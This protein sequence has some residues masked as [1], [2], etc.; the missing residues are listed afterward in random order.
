MMMMYVTQ[1][2]SLWSISSRCATS[3]LAPLRC[4][5]SSETP[6]RGQTRRQPRPS[7]LRPFFPPYAGRWNGPSLT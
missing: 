5:C 4:C 7:H 6:G 1:H 2:T 3:L